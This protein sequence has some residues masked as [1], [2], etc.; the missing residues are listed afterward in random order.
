MY[1]QGV[2]FLLLNASVVWAVIAGLLTWVMRSKLFVLV[3]MIAPYIIGSTFREI[4]GM[5]SLMGMYSTSVIYGAPGIVFGM[6]YADYQRVKQYLVRT[7]KL[8]FLARGGIAL[9]SVYLL[10]YFGQQI[11]SENPAVKFFLGFINGGARAQ[12]LISQVDSSGAMTSAAV[13][14]GSFGLLGV[15]HY[16]ERRATLKAVENKK[17]L[18][19]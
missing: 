11:L 18:E 8:A 19:T 16:I 3:V 9:S 12:E 13:I 15:T 5:Q 10:G 2:I 7:S 17:R 4:P 6:L 1:E 14:V